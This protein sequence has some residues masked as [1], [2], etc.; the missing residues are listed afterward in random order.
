M[1]ASARAASYKRNGP[2]GGTSMD[3]EDI[4]SALYVTGGVLVVAFVNLSHETARA[5]LWLSHLF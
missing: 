3:D 1:I 4:R 5:V 2:R